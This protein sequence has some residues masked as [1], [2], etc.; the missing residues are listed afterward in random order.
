MT[1]LRST[2]LLVA[3]CLV[4]R[5]PTASAAPPTLTHFF[6]AG[7]QQGSVVEVTAGGTFERWPVQAWAD[8]KGVEVKAA[9]EKG[10]L[11]VSIALDAV[12][13]IYWIRLYDEQ[14]ASALRPFVVGTLPEVL[15]RE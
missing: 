10:K 6:P 12:P 8:G 2:I 9:K 11:S 15:E 4:V 5:L 14:G 13:G 7:A 3:V 1:F